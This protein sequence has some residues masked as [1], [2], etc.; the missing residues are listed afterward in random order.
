[1][2]DQPGGGGFLKP[3]DHN[4]HL[5]LVTAVH[6]TFQRHDELAGKEKL[7][8]RIDYVCLDCPDADLVESALTS[9]PGIAGR[10]QSKVGK[11]VLGRIGQ[12]PSKT[13]Q[14]AWILG[15]F[16][17]GVDDAKAQ[18]WL[19]AHTTRPAQPTAPAGD[20]PWAG[21]QPPAAAPPQPPAQ[22]PAPPAAPPAAAAAPANGTTPPLTPEQQEALKA[23]GISL[24]A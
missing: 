7:H 9:H 8:A 21:Q 13:G 17:E 11:Q 3:A 23:L 15:P 6:E 2:F 4:G 12:A 1:M 24:P 20:D 18:A 16:T 14:P 22:A 19:T 10:L 5:L